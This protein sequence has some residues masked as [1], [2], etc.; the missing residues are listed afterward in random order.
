MR[1][2]K[3]EARAQKW[4]YLKEATGESATSKALDRAADYYL[5]MRGDTTAVPKGKLTDLMMAA[6]DWGSLTPEE[7]AEI[8]DTDELP[9]QCE[10]S[11][12]VGE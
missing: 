4:E 7:I 5:R 8:L 11:V 6:Q 12:S 9:V 2:E 10:V 3:T 1:I